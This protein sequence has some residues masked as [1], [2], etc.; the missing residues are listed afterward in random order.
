MEVV[1]WQEIYTEMKN[2]R[3][4]GLPTTSQS[5]DEAT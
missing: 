5:G 4:R 1:I 2:S 3:I